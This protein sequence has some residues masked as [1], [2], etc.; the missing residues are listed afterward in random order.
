MNSVVWFVN[1]SSTN[2]DKHTFC[3]REC[4][5]LMVVCARATTIRLMV[6]TRK[7]NKVIYRIEV[8]FGLETIS[9]H[10]GKTRCSIR[11]FWLFMVARA[12]PP[13]D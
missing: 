11:G 5:L 10:Q 8:L 1:G 13:S 9:K 12:R 3:M 7:H 2:E 4:W 6:V